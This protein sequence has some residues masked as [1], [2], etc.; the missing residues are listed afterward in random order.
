MGDSELG[1][2]VFW[3][4]MSSMSHWAPVNTDVGMV[5]GWGIWELV[6]TPA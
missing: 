4:A 1:T 5:V 6:N 3:T 2:D